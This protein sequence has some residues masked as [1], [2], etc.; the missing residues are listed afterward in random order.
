MT[1][2]NAVGYANGIAQSIVSLA[3]CV[4]PVIGGYVRNK[5]IVIYLAFPDHTFQLWSVSIQD[6]PSGYPLGF[7]VCAGVCALSVVQSFMIR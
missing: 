1:P 3:R 7:L 6:N 2:P 4:G 5:I